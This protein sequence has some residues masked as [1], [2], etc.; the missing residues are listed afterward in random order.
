MEFK[1]LRVSLEEEER[2]SK[3]SGNRNMEESLELS[4]IGGRDLL[5]VF[6]MPP[7]PID[8]RYSFHFL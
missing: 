8:L 5:C 3:G 1:G 2:V 7:I 4:N 6:P